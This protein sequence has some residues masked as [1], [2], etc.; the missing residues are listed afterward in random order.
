[1]L[2]VCRCFVHVAFRRR[3]AL[4]AAALR[5]DRGPEAGNGILIR[6][7]LGAPLSTSFLGGSSVLGLL[8]R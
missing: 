2:L 5:S 4:G 7:V 1:M 8:G 6:F 3:A